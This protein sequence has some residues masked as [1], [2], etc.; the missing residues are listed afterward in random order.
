MSRMR[1]GGNIEVETRTQAREDLGITKKPARKRKTIPSP[2]STIIT[3][4]DTKPTQQTTTPMVTKDSGEAPPR[5]TKKE[6]GKDTT[7]HDP[8]QSTKAKTPAIHQTHTKGIVPDHPNQS[9]PTTL[10]KTK[11]QIQI[12][13][14]S[15]IPTLSTQ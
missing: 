4:A 10:G 6:S 2:E 1:D 14:Q 11:P 13:N 15:L 12:R 8:P 9:A 3:A 7:D 5:I